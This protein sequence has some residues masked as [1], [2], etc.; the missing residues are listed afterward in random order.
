MLPPDRDRGRVNIE[1][2]ISSTGMPAEPEFRPGRKH[3]ASVADHQVRAAN[4]IERT[5]VDEK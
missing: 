2:V 4:L 1:V 5:V 3:V